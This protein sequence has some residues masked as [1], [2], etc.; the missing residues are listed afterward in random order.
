MSKRCLHMKH[1]VALRTHLCGVSTVL[2]RKVHKIS[3]NHRDHGFHARYQ[4]TRVYWSREVLALGKSPLKASFSSTDLSL[5]SKLN[6]YFLSPSK[7]SEPLVRF[8]GRRPRRHA[9]IETGDHACSARGCIVECISDI[10]F[11][12][13][14]I[15]MASV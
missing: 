6:L 3:R 5:I 9:A 12:Y 1:L 13:P 8:C 7:P 14:W 11:V 2:K 10:G 15:F 4:G